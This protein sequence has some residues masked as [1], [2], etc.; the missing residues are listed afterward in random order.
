VT[1]VELVVVKDEREAAHGAAERLA[2]A[3]GAGAHVA[4]SGGNTVGAAYEEAARLRSDWSRATVWWGD[5]RAV[6]PDDERS[7]YLLAERTLL[8]RLERPPAAVHRIRGELG[9]E[10]AA[11]EYDRLLVGVQL[12]LALNGIGEDGHTA[13]LFPN[14]PEL[15]EQERR[16]V[17]AEAR[18]EPFVPRVTLTLPVFRATELVVFLV[19]GAA[20]AQ[21][22]RRAFVDEPGPDTPASLVRGRHTVAILDRPA[23]G[24]LAAG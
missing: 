8:D 11:A 7:N 5:E 10:A 15:D 2:A 23:A 3:A 4:L 16:A 20:K 14:A 9:A 13:S 12:G 19:T 24:L 6:P 18:L 1:D 21:A 17:A 22:A